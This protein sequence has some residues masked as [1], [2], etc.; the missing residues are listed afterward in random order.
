M[1]KYR[2]N[3]LLTYR[4]HV[5]MND[6]FRV[7]V[8]QAFSLFRMSMDEKLLE[9]THLRQLQSKVSTDPSQVDL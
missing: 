8:F 5:A 1:S 2:Q 7:K 6:I 4:S 3:L 9:S